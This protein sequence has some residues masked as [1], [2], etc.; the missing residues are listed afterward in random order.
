MPASFEGCK[1][2]WLIW[3]VA[4]VLAF[5]HVSLRVSRQTQVKIPACEQH[6]GSPSWSWKLAVRSSDVAR[7]LR[8]GGHGPPISAAP[9]GATD[10]EPR[11]AS[12]A[13]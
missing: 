6:C 8:D 7:G 1:P 4:D 9:G 3:L 12:S 11:E 10:G 2:P 5:I 13:W